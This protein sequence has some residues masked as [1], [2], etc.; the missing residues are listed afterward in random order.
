M[1]AIPENVPFVG[2]RAN[3][4]RKWPLHLSFDASGGDHPL[5]L[6]PPLFHNHS[7]CIVCRTCALIEFSDMSSAWKRKA[8]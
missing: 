2:R 7:I 8:D 3:V 1:G 4:Y 5:R 6:D